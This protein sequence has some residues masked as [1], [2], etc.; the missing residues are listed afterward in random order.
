MR[1]LDDDNEDEHTVPSPSIAERTR[2]RIGRRTAAIRF[3]ANGGGS[4]GGTDATDAGTVSDAAVG[5]ELEW[6]EHIKQLYDVGDCSDA[7]M[8]AVLGAIQHTESTM[9]QA[10]IY[11]MHF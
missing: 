3:F 8:A 4:A 1:G 7:R 10:K 9:A 11:D 5:T 6:A 2:S